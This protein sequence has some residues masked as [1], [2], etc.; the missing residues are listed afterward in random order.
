MKKHISIGIIAIFLLIK[1]GFGQESPGTAPSQVADVPAPTSYIITVQDGNSCVWQQMTYS[2]LPSGVVVTNTRSYQELATGLNHL[3]NGK[4]VA[5][6]ETV[7]ILPSGTAAAINGQHQA[8]FPGDI[9]QGQIELVTPDGQ[10][11]YSRPTEL[12][13]FDGQKSVMIAEL[14]DSVGVVSG[15]NQVIYPDAFTDFK[16]DLVYTYTKA[17][18][19]Q[20]IVLREQPPTPESFGLD[21]DTA[22]LQVLTEFFNPPQPTIQSTTIPPQAGVA[23]TDQSLGF[24]QMQ[25]VLGKAFTLGTDLP[26]VS[27]AKSWQLLDGRQFLV[28]EVPVNAVI[29][30]LAALPL[31]AT[32]TSSANTIHI[33]SRHLI[34]P[35]QRLVRASSKAMP[36][37]KATLP[38]QGFVLDYNTVNSS[39]TNFI[40]QGDTTYYISGGTSLFGTNVFEG[41]TVIKYTNSSTA[42]ISI[43]GIEVCQTSP[44]RPAIFTSENDNSVGETISG[45]TGNPSTTSLQTSLTIFGTNTFENIRVCYAS[46]GVQVIACGAI[47]NDSQFI[48]V[49]N[50][51]FGV[52]STVNLKNDLFG[53]AVT[54]FAA[55][56]CNISAQNATFSGAS[57]LV[58]SPTYIGSSLKLTNCI[59]ANVTNV[60]NS[61][62]AV[63]FSGDHDGFYNSPVLG[64]GQ[65]TNS[66]YPFQAV[67][68]GSY[69]LAPGCNFFNSGTTNIDTTLLAALQTKT[70]Y[71]PLV[72][73]NATNSVNITFSPQAQRDI[74]TPDL[75][76]HYEPIDYL[77]DNYT[78]T[79]AILTVTNGAAIASYN[80]AG[81]LLQDGSS[82]ISTGSP[83][84]PNWFVRYSS[85]QEQPISLGGS[86]VAYGLTVMASPCGSVGPTGQFTFSKFVCPAE[87]GYLFYDYGTN[88]YNSLLIQNCEFWNSYADFSGSTNTIT[89]L[90]NNLFYRASLIATPIAPAYT[91]LSLSNNLVFGGEVFLF[92]EASANTWQAFN[93]A[94]DSTLI[95]TNRFVPLGFLTNG[96]NAYL[97][98]LY[99]LNPI[100]ASDVLTNGTMAYQA[101]PLGSFY[102]PTNSPL[103]NMGSTTADQV[104]LYHYTV[105]TN[106]IP[107]TN[108]VLDIGYHY[109]AVNTTGSPLDS[110][111]D[112]VPDYIEDANGNGI[113]DSGETNWSMAFLLQPMSQ[114]VAAGSNVTFNVTVVG[115][116]PFS[117]QWLFNGANLI[118]ATNASVTILNAQTNNA[119]NYSVIVTN[120]SGGVT[121]SVAA[122][123]VMS[124]STDSDYDGRN[125]AQETT[126]GTD[127]Y[128]SASVTPVRL[129]YWRFDNTNLWS[130][131]AGQLPMVV[132][133]VYGIL[134][135]STNA[136]QIGSTNPAILTYRDVETNGNANINLRNGAVRFWF[137]PNWAT[138]NIGG[139]GPGSPGRLIEIGNYNPAFTN[140]W[141]SLYLSPDGSQIA[142]GSS[143]NGAG[144]VNLSANLAWSS[145]QWHQIVLTYSP[146]NSSLYLDGLLATNGSGSVYFPNVAE[147]A[148]GF[149]VGSDIFGNNQA[150]GD[151]D[152]LETFNYPL[153]AG[154][155]SSNYQAAIQ[156]STGT[157]GLPNIWQI[158]NFG[159]LGVDPNADPDSD[160]LSN[161]QEYQLG[162]NPNNPDT[163]GDGRNDWQE[164]KDDTDPL[165][166]ASKATSIYRADQPHINLA[167]NP[168]LPI[169][170]L[171][172]PGSG[173]TVIISLTNA[174][175]NVF[176]DVYGI[177]NLASPNWLWL[178]RLQLGAQYTN[179]TTVFQVELFDVFTT[180]DTDGDG[181]T[182]VYEEHVSHT[183]PNNPDSDY[184]GRSDGQETLLDG[185]D[186][187]NAN[188]VTNVMLAGWNFNN[189]NTWA[190][191]QGQLPMQATNVVGIPSWGT[192]AVRIDTNAPAILRFHDVEATNDASANINCRKGTVA[193][194]FAPDW[195]SG[196]GPGSPGRFIEMG[197]QTA[198]NGWWSLY[199]SPDGTQLMFGTQTNG[200]ALTN[201]TGSIAWVSNQWHQIVITY[202]PTNSSLY[203]DGLPIVTNGLGTTYFPNLTERTNGFCI[204]SDLNGTNQARG[205]F[206]ELQTFNYPLSATMIATNYQNLYQALLLSDINGDGIPD[207][208]EMNYF[209]T[210]NVNL[211]GDPDGDGLS[212]RQ[213]YLL[214][215]NPI[216]NDSGQP[217]SRSNYSYTLTDWLQGISG[218]R[219]GSVSLDNEGNVLS[220]SQ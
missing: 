35:T 38:T 68:A 118:N 50:P 107:E 142:F 83:L 30:G 215:L 137:A 166:S 161:L 198:T 120:L 78:I 103:I 150:D 117:Y 203:V 188:S 204:G 195:N 24:G 43:N 48:N 189:T 84:F 149:R 98:C 177:T 145:N 169:D 59:L 73:S 126:D 135:W 12:S 113:V 162:T 34:L 44:Y 121:S 60:V 70:T 37:T 213:E 58:S 129:G 72:F 148:T 176:Y 17:G 167:N 201:L 9:Y 197:S 75:G 214:G 86:N 207:I 153:D 116:G 61:G 130:G 175:P 6:S 185:N 14:K 125:D 209:G 110:N 105:T 63:S 170:L 41:G 82:I 115:I 4:W 40:F 220:V 71:P 216:I 211:N 180:N 27:V 136:L 33:V 210:L 147:R 88:V 76:Y 74:D 90:Q 104:G 191:E 81:I 202:S 46:V 208:W 123:I 53:N 199:L 127:P 3:V 205:I 218:V 51:L 154:T 164:T 18:F 26:P 87:D 141:W 190:G 133:N 57:Y 106:Q 54:V 111:G 32:Q 20:D 194:W 55:F 156:W 31:P 5:S 79:N 62:G 94:F 101:G 181:L 11:L 29:E 179:S 69:Y 217:G 25:M 119:G 97:N 200:L 13:Y 178:G 172:S 7:D 77:V 157:N 159:T 102:Q 128:N 52:S 21:P 100:G 95:Q 134:S 42:G 196:V 139:T 138:T 8:Y 193:F 28:E 186:P 1:A 152:E 140:G 168:S 219:T 165:N 212:N 23:L 96:N 131:D 124:Q 56:Q 160:H 91:S 64:A 67:G 19:E 80:E 171:I 2:K 192:N 36:M 16:A 39:L 182:D 112:G 132:T 93:N 99:R 85:V 45:S 158:N 144:G 143:T 114:V 89:V 155:I 187:N 15:D 184:D 146:T 10:Q 206:D 163:D 65:I 66:Y 22:R 173:S 47:I 122:L 183:D 108:S 49:S 174:Q 151:F 92:N 109:V